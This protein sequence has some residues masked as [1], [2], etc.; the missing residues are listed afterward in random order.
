MMKVGVYKITIGKRFY[1]GKSVNLARRKANHLSALKNGRHENQIL[2]RAYNKYG[3]VDWEVVAY[4]DEDSVDRLEKELVSLCAGNKLC[5]NMAMPDGCKGWRPC[6]ETRQRMRQKKL[7]RKLSAEH[8]AKIGASGLGRKMPED[9]KK[10]IGDAH[11]GRKMHPKVAEILRSK[12]CKPCVLIT[13]GGLPMLFE[14]MRDASEMVGVSIPA[15]R[16]Y[17]NNTSPWPPAGSRS[18][19]AGYVGFYA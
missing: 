8:R 5:M 15:I 11:R 14:S 1:Y 16:Y 6:E 3:K 7:G 2:Q 18:R 9:A 4:C 17:L 12:H 10:K 19:L 13:P